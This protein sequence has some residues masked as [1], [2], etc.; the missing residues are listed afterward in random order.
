MR[1][2]ESQAGKDV[3]SRKEIIHSM[4]LRISLSMTTFLRTMPRVPLYPV[5]RDQMPLS[6]VVRDQM[7]L[8]P[9]V[10]DWSRLRNLF[11]K[12]PKLRKL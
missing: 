7:P 11:L 3:G 1:L 5:E 12:K 2:F 10:R 6:P 8:C 9:V 4:W